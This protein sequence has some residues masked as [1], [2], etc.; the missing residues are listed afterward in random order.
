VAESEALRQRGPVLYSYLSQA[1]SQ[2]LPGAVRWTQPPGCNVYTHLQT[3]MT[4]EMTLLCLQIIFNHS[5]KI[6]HYFVTNIFRQ[7]FFATKRHYYQIFI[8]S[9]Q[10]VTDSQKQC[11]FL[12][13]PVRE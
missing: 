12:A 4:S 10:N 6:T 8:S 11:S 9:L 7:F 13:H 3:E 2:T 1:R 5:V